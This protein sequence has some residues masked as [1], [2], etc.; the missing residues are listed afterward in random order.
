MSGAN[1]RASMKASCSARRD[2]P[3]IRQRCASPRP[4]RS[5][6]VIGQTGCPPLPRLRESPVCLLPAWFATT[7]KRTSLSL[8]WASSHPRRRRPRVRWG[9]DRRRSFR[10]HPHV[11]IAHPLGVGRGGVRRSRA[12]LLQALRGEA[13]LQLA[14]VPQL[15]LLDGDVSNRGASRSARQ[16]RRRGPE[17][18]T[19]RGSGRAA[20][21]LRRATNAGLLAKRIGRDPRA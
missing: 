10:R 6:V 16:S 15:V 13:D 20:Q 14:L 2:A 4:R 3:E 7:C 17:F 9:R 19:S 1:V 11:G 18:R 5:G 12:G 21:K 8:A